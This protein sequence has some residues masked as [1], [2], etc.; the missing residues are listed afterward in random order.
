MAK[1]TDERKGELTD[2]AKRARRTVLRALHQAGS[3]HPGGSFSQMEFM[4]VLYLEKLNHK[5]NEPEWEE[6]DMVFLSKG[7]A[8]P[9]WYAVMAEAGYF[10]AEEIVATLRKPESRFQGHPGSEHTPGVDISSGSLGQGL[11]VANGVAL[12][13]RLDGKNRRAYC[14]IGD[15]ELQEGQVWEAA[16]SAAHFKL[17]NVC[18]IVDWNKIQLDTWTDQVKTL[19]DLKGKWATFGWHVIEIDGHDFQQIDDAFDEAAA[20]KGKPSVIIAHTIKGKGVTFMENDAKWHGLAPNEQ[21]L[22]L[23]LKELV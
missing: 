3:G 19:G 18:A 11:S 9:G 2:A 17:D 21:E 14:V 6:R 7:H 10:P 20:V 13:A 15:G 5:P 22:E 8:A 16:M 4:L 12:A 1:L 23:A